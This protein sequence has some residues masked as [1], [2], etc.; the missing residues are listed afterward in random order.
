MRP[1][2][3]GNNG[4]M[5]RQIPGL[6][7]HLPRSVTSGNFIEKY[8][9]RNPQAILS[10]AVHVKNEKLFSDD[11]MGRSVV[12]AGVVIPY[13]TLYMADGLVQEPADNG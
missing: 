11:P 8:S 2:V 5:Q 10:L 13:Y 7:T 3:T 4:S 12:N 9:G 1:V 6:A